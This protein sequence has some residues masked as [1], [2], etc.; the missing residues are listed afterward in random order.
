M[1]VKKCNGFVADVL[2]DRL[3]RGECNCGWREKQANSYRALARKG[4]ADV[5]LGGVD[6]S[7][8]MSGAF[9]CLLPSICRQILDERMAQ[10]SSGS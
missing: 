9:Y 6:S 8:F 1:W 5:L 4:T 2:T 3:M 10:A 7:T